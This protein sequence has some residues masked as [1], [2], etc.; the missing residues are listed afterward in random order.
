MFRGR[1]FY[2]LEVRRHNPHP[3]LGLS[4][5]CFAIMLWQ[6][7]SPSRH[8]PRPGAGCVDRMD[9]CHTPHVAH[10]AATQ[11]TNRPNSHY[12]FDRKWRLRV[13][14]D[15]MPLVVVRPLLVLFSWAAYRQPKLPNGRPIEVWKYRRR[16]S[17]W[18]FSGYRFDVKEEMGGACWRSSG[19]H[20]AGAGPEAG[21]KVSFGRL[22]PASK[23]FFF[24][25]SGAVGIVARAACGC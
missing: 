23:G 13:A 17:H 10:T 25:R 5:S 24:G 22:G 21:E 14:V 18:F 2:R 8:D 12:A 1:G 20:F 11:R 16:F 9:A 19:H 3:S 6:A 4:R 15:V 7:P